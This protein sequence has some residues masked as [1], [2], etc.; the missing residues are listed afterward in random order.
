MILR[1]ISGG[2]SGETRFSGN[3]GGAAGV[4]M[5]M[6]VCRMLYQRKEGA[7]AKSKDRRICG[8]VV[9]GL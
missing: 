2:M 8:M 9:D 6:N 4:A 3:P 5:L 7:F 1:M